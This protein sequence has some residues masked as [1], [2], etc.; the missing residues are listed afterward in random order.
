[1]LNK[2]CLT[3]T[4]GAMAPSENP[5]TASPFDSER[6]LRAA[7]RLR[8]DKP[9]ADEAEAQAYLAAFKGHSLE[10]IQRQVQT[11]MGP[12]PVEDAQELAF[13]ALECERPR[14]IQRLAKAALALDPRCLDAQVALLLQEVASPKVQA[15]RLKLLADTGRSEFELGLFHAYR[16]RVWGLLEARPWLRLRLTQAL[17][18][19]QAGKPKQAIVILEE[20]L[21][22]STEDALGA[23]YH[24]LRLYLLKGLQKPLQALLKAYPQDEGTLFA[25]ARVLERFRSGE[26]RLAQSALQEA[27]ATNPHVEELLVATRRPPKGKP[28]PGPRGSL[29]EAA[30]LLDR[31]LGQP[32]LADRAAMAWLFRGGKG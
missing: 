7:R 12:D 28:V 11:T 26:L 25:W 8:E 31:Y 27:R 29:E 23:R 13:Q 4:G 32:W 14:E 19:E 18:L 1:M 6:L 5:R 22:L 15:E 21:Q 10:D 30:F 16:G 24:L 9:F 2:V 17:T 20:L 3:S